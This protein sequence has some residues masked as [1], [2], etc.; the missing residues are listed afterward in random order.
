MNESRKSYEEWLEDEADRADEKYYSD[1]EEGVGIHADP[2]LVRARSDLV[3]ALAKSRPKSEHERRMEELDRI[4]RCRDCKAQLTGEQYWHQD[5]MCDDCYPDYSERQRK[6]WAD[7]KMPEH[8][9]DF[10]D[11]DI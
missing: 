9:F 3:K 6:L 5:G 8:K 4:M 11:L 2:Q 1:A 10:D 7:I